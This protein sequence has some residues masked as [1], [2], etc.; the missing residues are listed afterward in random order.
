MHADTHTWAFVRQPAPTPSIVYCGNDGGLFRSTDGGTTWT[1]LN[2][3]ALQTTLFYN[4]SLRPDATASETVGTLQDNGIQTTSGAAGQSWNSPQGGDGRD[5]AYD[6]VTA[7]RVYGTSGFWQTPCTR[8]F[9]ST[10][11]GTDLPATTT[12]VPSGPDIL[13]GGRPAMPDVISRGLLPTRVP[14]AS[15]M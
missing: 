2:A 11:D 12:L 9:V 7:S 3:G 4:I 5:V 10:A 6:G 8:L 1:A 14:R 13:P 15:S